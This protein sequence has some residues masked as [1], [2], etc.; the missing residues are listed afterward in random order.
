MWWTEEISFKDLLEVGPNTVPSSL[1][2]SRVTR[3]RYHGHV[4]SRG[5][6]E[7]G[8]RPRHGLEGAG[9]DGSTGRA[10]VERRGRGVGRGRPPLI[11]VFGVRVGGLVIGQRFP[12][13]S[14]DTGL[15]V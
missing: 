8:D 2:F 14:L 1:F 12:T 13:V 5:V 4:P 3:P 9:A 6:R 11:S 10:E 15:S 7:V